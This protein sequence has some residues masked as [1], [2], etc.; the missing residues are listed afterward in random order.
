MQKRFYRKFIKVLEENGIRYGLLPG[1]KDIWCRDYMPIQTAKNRFIQF[2]YAPSYLKGYKHLITDTKK[3]CKAIGIRPILSNIILD[4]GNVVASKNRAIMTSRILKDNPGYGKDE[5]I[6]KLKTFLKVREVIVLPEDPDDIF[7]HADGMVRFIKR[8]TILVNDYKRESKTFKD[9]FYGAIRKAGLKMV[10]LP[11]NPYRNA[12]KL[13][14]TGCYINYLQVGKMIFVP[15]FGMIED[16]KA[17]KVLKKVFKAYKV[18]QIPSNQIAKRG[19]VLNCIS[20]GI[21]N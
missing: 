15:S 4:G 3:V 17:L 18:V 10:H 9:K 21:Q 19:G 1:T 16:N 5:L 8:N 13:D 11:Y 12:K 2:N 14:A 7:G 6:K 20:W